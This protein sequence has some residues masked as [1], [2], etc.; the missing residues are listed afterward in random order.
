MSNASTT[1]KN[2]AALKVS[3]S[4]PAVVAF[5]LIALPGPQ[6]KQGLS[7]RALM[8]GA[9]ARLMICGMT[10]AC[11]GMA[12]TN[13][14]IAQWMAT[15]L[16][17][18]YPADSTDSS[19]AESKTVADTDTFGAA[20]AV[21]TSLGTV[22]ETASAM[23]QAATRLIDRVGGFCLVEYGYC[24]LKGKGPG[25][26]DWAEVH[27]GK[28]LGR[29]ASSETMATTFM[30]FTDQRAALKSAKADSSPNA[31]GTAAAIVAAAV[32]IES[33]LDE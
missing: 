33:E 3:A 6:A 28:V 12:Y 24:D 30:I 31:H 9:A 20:Y 5:E 32:A 25:I 1:S 29:V 23:R 22:E 13:G 2:S 26:S 19:W 18:Y 16:S 14:E 27:S 4:T 7:L 10:G 15:I 21:R 11:T 8:D 17:T